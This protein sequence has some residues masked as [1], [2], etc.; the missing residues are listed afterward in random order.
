MGEKRNGRCR[1]HAQERVKRL[2][3]DAHIMFV[4]LARI[5]L[6]KQDSPIV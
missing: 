6:N 1:V 2:L 5:F 3:T 4:I